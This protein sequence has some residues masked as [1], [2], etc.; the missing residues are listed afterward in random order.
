MQE[1]EIKEE[2]VVDV[3]QEETVTEETV[4]QAVDDVS[5]SNPLNPVF[6]LITIA[7]AAILVFYII[8]VKTKAGKRYDDY[9]APVDEKE[10]KVKKLLPIG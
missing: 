1:T 4:E 6:T 3:S 7:I 8:T 10:C 9:I 5:A 2:V